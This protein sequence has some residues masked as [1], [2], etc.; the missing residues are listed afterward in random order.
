MPRREDRTIWRDVGSTTELAGGK[1]LG[2]PKIV[3]AGIR[4]VT[5]AIDLVRFDVEK[6]HGDVEGSPTR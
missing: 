4:D 3:T 5:G 1:R 2:L 6:C